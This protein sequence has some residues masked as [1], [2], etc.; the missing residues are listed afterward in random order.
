MEWN[1]RLSIFKWRPVNSKMNISFLISTYFHLFYYFRIVRYE[2]TYTEDSVYII[3]GFTWGTPSRIS[4][5]AQY[6]DD[7]WTI[8]GNLKP[9]RSSHGAIT[10]KGKTMNIG[11]Y[12]QSGTT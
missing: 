11:G 2:T 7:I 3:G 1:K 4:T 12:P 10:V 5:I 8:A 6:K 9:A